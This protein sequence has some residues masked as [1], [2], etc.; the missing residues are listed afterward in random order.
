MSCRFMS[1]GGADEAVETEPPASPTPMP[2]TPPASETPAP[3]VRGRHRGGVRAVRQRQVDGVYL[4]RGRP[5]VRRD[6]QEHLLLAGE[7]AETMPVFVGSDQRAENNYSGRRP[8]PLSA[9]FCPAPR[10]L[11]VDPDWF[12]LVLPR[13]SQCRPIGSTTPAPAE[14]ADPVMPVT[15]PMAEPTAAPVMPVAPPTVEPTVEPTVLQSPP[16]SP[17]PSP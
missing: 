6:G 9:P 15:P 1:L 14:T 7:E 10:A 16:Q 8:P 17:P 2:T 13:L 3:L 4:L 5:R 12:A 11:N